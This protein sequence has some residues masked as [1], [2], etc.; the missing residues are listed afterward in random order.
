M[1]TFNRSTVTG[2]FQNEAQAQQAM[3]DL[4]N[5]G[6]TTDQIRYSVHRGGSGIFDSLLG[7]GLGNDEANY[8][9]SEF[10]AGRTVV[11]VKTDDRQQ[12][13]RDVMH[14][15]NAYDWSS[16]SGQAADFAG[17]SANAYTQTSQNPQAGDTT[18]TTD[19]NATTAYD[20]TTD[21]GARKMQLRE[22][23]LTAQKQQIQAGEVGIHKDIV[24]EERTMNVPVN[25]EEVYIERK[26][27]SGN[28]PSDAVIGQD[29]TLRVPVSEER[30]QVIKQPVVKEEIHIGKRVVQDNQQV[31]DTVRREEARVDRAGNVNVDGTDVDDTNPRY[32]QDN[33]NR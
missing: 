27:V 4:Q 15:Y 22:E 7:L 11:T 23:Q 12:E 24:S 3:A 29:E 19:T 17:S 6:F 8:Y 32:N 14:R 25:R 20:T 31:S 18:D 2:V 33:S 5:A 21:Q 28:V 1:S 16:R 30:V 9:N 13:A 26:P 10:M